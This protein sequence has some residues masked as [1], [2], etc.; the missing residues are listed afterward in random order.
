MSDFNKDDPDEVQIDLLRRIR[1]QG[2][3]AAYQAALEVCLN[4][5]AQPSARA[6]A[7]TTLFRVAG[8]LEKREA[9][10]GKEPHEMSPAELAA[11]IR[12]GERTLAAISARRPKDPSGGGV[13]D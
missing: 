3:E 9:D 1:T 8:Y 7:S 2:V 12:K 11:A 4:K 10:Q 6:T 5:A 13:F